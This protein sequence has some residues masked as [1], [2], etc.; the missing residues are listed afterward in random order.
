MDENTMIAGLGTNRRGKDHQT[1]LHLLTLPNVP[2][3]SLLLLGYLWA[4]QPRSQ[5][6]L[7]VFRAGEKERP[8][9]QVWLKHQRKRGNA[10]VFERCWIMFGARFK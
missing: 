9:E 4:L 2:A 10:N 7:S 5:S 1:G 8:W 3:R 6:L